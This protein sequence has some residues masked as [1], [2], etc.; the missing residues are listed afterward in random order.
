ME[1]FP[2]VHRNS[3]VNAAILALFSGMYGKILA[4]HTSTLKET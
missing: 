2:G 1:T 3:M 4:C